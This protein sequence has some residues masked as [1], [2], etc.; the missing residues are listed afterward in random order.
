MHP[1][2]PR[3]RPQDASRQPPE[4]IPMHRTTRLRRD[5]RPKLRWL[6]RLVVAAGIGLS[7]LSAPAP[8]ALSAPNFPDHAIKVVVPIL[9]GAAAD[10]LPRIV[11][12]RLSKRFGQPVVIENRPGAES[13]GIR[14]GIRPQGASDHQGAW[15]TSAGHRRNGRGWSD[16][17]DC[18]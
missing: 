5:E 3:E 16:E 2:E 18:I 1:A 17:V 12:E 14:D 10:I 11:A 7:A 6:V 4:E 8:F 9:P 13:G 15:R